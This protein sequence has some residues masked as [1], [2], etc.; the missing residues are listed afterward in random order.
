MSDEITLHLA[1]TGLVQGVNYRWSLQAEA[2][3]L[4]L[5]GWVRNRRD[6]SV[7]AVVRGPEGG[8]Q[9]LVEW[10]RRGPPAARVEGVETAFSDDPVDPGFRQLPTV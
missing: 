7:E 3:R 10:A 6:G 9:K 5:D 2:A 8:V 1:I 4:A